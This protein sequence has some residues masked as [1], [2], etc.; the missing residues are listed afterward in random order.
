M[1]TFKF[2]TPTRL[3]VLSFILVILTGALLLTLPAASKSGESPGFFDAL[4]TA[5]S[6]TCVTGLVVLDTYSTWSIFG[7]IVIISLIQ[8]GGLGFMS[9]IALFALFFKR[10][11]GLSERKVLMQASGSLKLSGVVRL[12]KRIFIGT[13]LCELIGAV[14]LAIRFCPMMGFSEGI[15]NAVFHSISAFCNA[16]FD[17]M[18][19]YGKFSSFSSPQL[20]SDLLVNLTLMGL[21]VTGGLGFIVWGDLFKQ[22][23]KIKKYELHTKLVLITT[24]I[25]IL[26]GA[27][28][29]LLFEWNYSLVDLDIKNK[30][31][32]AFFQSI[33]PRTAGFNTVEL[34]SLSESGKLL[35]SALMLIGGSPGSTAGGLKT[36]TFIILILGAFAEARRKDSICILKRKIEDEAFRQASVIFTFYITAVIASV[37]IICAAEEAYS[38]S[39]IIYEVCS[40]IGTAGLTLG[41]TPGLTM[42]SQTILIILMFIGR[43]GGLSLMLALGETRSPVPINRP[44]EKI[45]IG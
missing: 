11:I 12:I 15:Y 20:Q 7:Q 43:V 42:T 21:I 22:R 29:F 38:L 30:I 36:T 19:K 33:S 31:L 6:A 35:S 39:Y 45:I 37:L 8:I 16:G 4:F 1:K 5:T 2:L 28:L 40:A 17:I 26:G 44:E 23:L 18:G 27:S 14:L 9:F 34:S 41:I 3:I 24:L 13:F 32:A 25:L 10:R